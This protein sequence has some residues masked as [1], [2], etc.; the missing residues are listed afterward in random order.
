MKTLPVS[1]LLVGESVTVRV[2]K[3]ATI[4]CIASSERHCEGETCGERILWT[5]TP[6]GK[7]MPVDLP[8]PVGEPAISHW[9]TCPDRERFRT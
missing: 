4:E 1:G 8:I 2:G 3:T 5:R 9:A 7:P 6:K